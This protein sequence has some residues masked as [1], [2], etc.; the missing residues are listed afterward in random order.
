MEVTRR[1][2][3]FDA[4]R[5]EE[6]ELERVLYQVLRAS[7]PM[8]FPFRDHK[9]FIVHTTENFADRYKELNLGPA[10]ACRFADISSIV[11]SSENPRWVSALRRGISTLAVMDCRNSQL[12]LVQR[13]A[14][15][16]EF[17]RRLQSV[18]RCL[19]E[20]G[21]PR[22]TV[23]LFFPCDL[24]SPGSGEEWLAEFVKKAERLKDR[25]DIISHGKPLTEADRKRLNLH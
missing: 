12:K 10:F 20:E 1:T 19:D 5:S 18:A 9:C 25:P 6:D 2:L 21:T 3:Y 11:P 16:E 4:A 24:D 8:A 15:K 23:K 7:E 14:V 13:R 17:L 22:A